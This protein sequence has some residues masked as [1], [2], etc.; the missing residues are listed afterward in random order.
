MKFIAGN[1]LFESLDER[2]L[3]KVR[4]WRNSDSVRNNMDYQKLISPEQHE[5]WF[6][7]IQNI[8]NIYFVAYF[9]NE[10]FALLNFKN[11]C[12]D[13]M[14][15]EAGTFVGE[16]HFLCSEIPAVSVIL[17][18]YFAFQA[19]GMKK[20]RS[21][22]LKSNSVVHKYSISLGYEIIREDDSRVWWEINKETFF[23]K[24][25]KLIKS[26]KTLANIKETW[27]IEF[28]RNSLDE[29]FLNVFISQMNKAGTRFNMQE[30]SN[31]I[32]LLIEC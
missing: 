12:W 7:G 25:N 19:L 8:H 2:T 24:N 32:Q 22:T 21:K 16:P 15:T 23:K 28:E 6:M 1:I 17:L 29:S 10:A 30:K 13:A 26:A 18:K 14:T 27:V 9:K 11:I 4:V 20:I 3:D 31:R 5:E